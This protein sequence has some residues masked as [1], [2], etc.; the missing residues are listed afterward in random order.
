MTIEI[1]RLNENFRMEAS[2]ENG[3]S[4][5]ID[6][7]AGGEGMSPM[8]LLLAGIGGC[9]SIDIIDIL[10]KQRQD[11]KDLKVKVDGQR[12]K[13][14]V[15]ALFEKIHIH[16]HFF[17]NLDENKVQRAIKLSLETYCSVSKMLEKTA[18]VTSSYQIEK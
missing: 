15:P 18:V 16:Y 3:N 10:K 5:Q 14:V 11:L 12:Q 4:I 6:N 9:S 7:I 17:G 13:D 1:K 8:Q 2:N